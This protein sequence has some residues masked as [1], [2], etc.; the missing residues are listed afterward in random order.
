LTTPPDP[1]PSPLSALLAGIACGTGAAVFW[2]AAFVAALHGLAAGLQPADLVFHRY[3]WAGLAFVPFF[4]R[5]GFADLGG[6]SWT[7]AIVLTLFVGPIFSTIS[8]SGFL[9]VP[10]GH[11]AVIQPSCAALGGLALAALVLREPVPAQRVLGAVI[12]VTG[13]VVIGGEAAT[14]IGRQGLLGDIMFAGAGLM[15]ATFGMLLRR[16]RIAPTL[17]VGV[18]SVVALLYVPY[19]WLAHGFDRMVS[20]GL[21]ENL[22]QILVQGLL[23]GVLSTYLFARSVILLGAGRAAVFPSLVPGFTLLVGFL[24]LHQVPSIAQLAGFAVVLVGFR[25]TQK[26]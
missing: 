13:L 18:T 14:S 9:F 20:A 17:S 1:A 24:V 21:W 23:A 2:A 7:R 4:A 11:G 15:F 22:L 10:L 19:Y 16:W 25:L 3:V 26:A 8:N 6:V 5:D 12:I